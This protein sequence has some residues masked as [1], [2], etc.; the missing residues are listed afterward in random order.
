MFPALVPTHYS[1]DTGR[2][3]PREIWEGNKQEKLFEMREE[4]G[5]GEERI[6]EEKR[7]EDERGGGEEGRGLRSPSFLFLLQYHLH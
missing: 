7:K 4:G 1:K 6:G 5:G 3:Q 2:S